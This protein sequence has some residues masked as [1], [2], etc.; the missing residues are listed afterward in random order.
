MKTVVKEGSYARL[1]DQEA[2]KRVEAG[3]K[4]CSKSEWKKNVRDG[5]VRERKS[6]SKE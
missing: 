1:E 4:F 2:D 6:K 3:W 5:E